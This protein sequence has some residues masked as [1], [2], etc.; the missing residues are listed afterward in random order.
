[1]KEFGWAIAHHRKI[2]GYAIGGDL[3]KNPRNLVPVAAG[4]T[5]NRH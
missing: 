1:L 2:P 3:L 4:I 5:I